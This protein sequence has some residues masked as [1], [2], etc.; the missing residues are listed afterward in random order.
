[1][2][3]KSY[4]RYTPMSDEFFGTL[5]VL[6]FFWALFFCL[7]FIA[8]GFDRWA[9]WGAITLGFI[10]AI[11]ATCFVALFTGVKNVKNFDFQF[12]KKKGGE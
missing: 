6:G 8:L 9:F 1:M 7:L 4:G 5:K 12:W 11:I 2:A 10:F 3:Y